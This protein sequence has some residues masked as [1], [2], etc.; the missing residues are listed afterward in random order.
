M[1][2]LNLTASHS[3]IALLRVQKLGLIFQPLL[4]SLSGGLRSFLLLPAEL[5]E[6]G[7]GAFEEVAWMADAHYQSSKEHWYGVET[8]KVDFVVR[9]RI[10]GSVAAG[11]FNEAINDA[12]LDFESTTVNDEEGQET[13]Y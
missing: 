7:V 11:V 8:V 2:Q 1:L 4:R 3:T 12:E 13:T 9:E 6:F 5:W 10:V